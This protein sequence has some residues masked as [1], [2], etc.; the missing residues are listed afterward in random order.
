MR[1]AGDY[2]QDLE[3]TN[4]RLFAAEKIQLSP[5]EFVRQLQRAYRAGQESFRAAA[6]DGIPDF[7]RGFMK[8]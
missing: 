3:R 6:D 5:A 4:P 2:T 7:M 1:T 8:K